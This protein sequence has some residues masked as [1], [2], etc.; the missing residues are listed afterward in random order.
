M[1]LLSPAELRLESSGF[2]D[3]TSGESHQK[4]TCIHYSKIINKFTFLDVYLLPNMQELVKKLLSIVIFA[5]WILELKIE[6]PVE[7]RPYTASEANGK[8]YQFKRLSFGLTNA[9][10]W[11][12]RIM[13][14]IID[15]NECQGTFVYLD[16]ITVCGKTKREHD[17]NLKY[18]L[19]VGAKFNLT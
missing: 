12:R 3:G 18:F 2:G 19:G 6:I 4:R 7:D 16:N 13:D 15:S 10:P 8:L 11:F 14:D 9:V 5:L 1:E 17:E